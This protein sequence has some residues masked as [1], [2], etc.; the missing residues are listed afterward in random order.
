M[1][2]IELISEVE[3]LKKKLERAE[4]MSALWKGLAKM[5][6]Y[7]IIKIY[8]PQLD[9]QLKKICELQTKQ[10]EAEAAA[11]MYCERTV[12]AEDRLEELLEIKKERSNYT[13]CHNQI[14][15]QLKERAEGAEDRLAALKKDARWCAIECNRLRWKHPSQYPD[16]S[17]LCNAIDRIFETTED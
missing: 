14:L 2:K 13:L 12:K 5:H 11:R 9:A 17:S 8:E 16:G 15:K 7:S 1:P 4:H 3:L 10:D 6:R